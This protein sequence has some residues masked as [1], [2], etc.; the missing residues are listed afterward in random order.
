MSPSKKRAAS[1]PSPASR[2]ARRPMGSRRVLLPDHV[3]EALSSLVRARMPAVPVMPADAAEVLRA[4][5]LD[6]MPA[7]PPQPT[8]D[9]RSSSRRS[10]R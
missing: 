2:P 4:T 7:S 1:K 6:R 8:V 5:V 9:K 10:G 3:Q